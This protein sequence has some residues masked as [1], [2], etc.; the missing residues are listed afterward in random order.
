MIQVALVL[1][2]I[3]I[4]THA[5]VWRPVHCAEGLPVICLSV[6]PIYRVFSREVIKFMN[7]KLTSHP[8]CYP[9]EGSEE[10]AHFEFQSDGSM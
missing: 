1:F 10:P 3:G 6:S 5:D 9:R 4:S 2:Q 7:V 8:S